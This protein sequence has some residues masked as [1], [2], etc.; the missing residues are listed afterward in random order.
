MRFGK[1]GLPV[2][3]LLI[4]V[5]VW[6]WMPTKASGYARYKFPIQLARTEVDELSA[7]EKRTKDLPGRGIDLADLAL[8]YANQARSQGNRT[9]YDKAEAAARASLKVLPVSNAG[10]HVA[11]AK[12]FEANHRFEE[13]IT[14]A[15]AALK[16][17]ADST[18][19][20]S[21]LVTSYLARGDSVEASDAA[22][23]LLTLH[24]STGHYALKGLTLFGQNR[25][26]EG[27]FMFKKG[28]EIETGDNRTD[29]AWARALLGRHWLVRGGYR[30]AKW[31]LN[32]AARIAPESDFVHS[33][34]AE[35]HLRSQEL[36]DAETEARR[37]LELSPQP[38]YLRLL[39][40]I[41]AAR[42][43]GK[44]AN[45]YFAE[46][47]RAVREELAASRQGHRLDLVQILLEQ[48]GKEKQ[49]EAVKLAREEIGIRQ[50]GDS[51]FWLAKAFAASDQNELAIT[52]LEQALRRGER[53]AE[54]YHF[55][56]ELQRRVKN[57]AASELY[58]RLASKK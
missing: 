29:S 38:R 7:L 42:G 3:V 49:E 10:A 24:P 31:L 39:G 13:A 41:R 5:C 52:S 57:Q 15:K 9:F 47:E 35:L 50:S 48:G 1:I 22:D 20:W 18:G 14:E 25:S 30:E 53:S 21:V 27:V 6:Q 4:G 16:D 8:R 46:A 12:V 56:A 43:D 34:L 23:H 33:L 2:V 26:E 19:G 51:Y 36:V 55:A 40:Q 45:G 37:A 58:E 28:F 32:E 17:S 11:L 44:S 54:R